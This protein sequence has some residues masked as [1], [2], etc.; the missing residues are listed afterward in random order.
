[1][2]IE[3]KM[4]EIS[5]EKLYEESIVWDAHSGIEPEIPPLMGPLERMRKAGL[6]YTQINVGYDVVPWEKTFQVIG[7]YRSWLRDHADEYLLVGGISD[8]TR[9]KS[10]NKMAVAFDIEGMNALCGSVDLVEVYYR[11]GVRQM[12]IAYNANNLAGGGCHGPDIDLQ[13]FGHDVIA[14]MNEV[15][16][17]VDCS[18]CGYRTTLQAAE[19]SKKPISFSH[20]NSRNLH[21]HERNI[22]DEQIQACASTGGVIG[23]TGVR[24]YLG[25]GAEDA[26]L[27]LR[28]I[29]YMC[30]LV[31]AEHVG[32][33]SDFAD[34]TDGLASL[35]NNEKYYWP[36]EQYPN[37]GEIGFVDIEVFPDIANAL[38]QRGYSEKHIR[39]IMGENF[40]RLAA[41]NWS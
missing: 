25:S 14:A 21:D 17:I 33:G 10:E 30:E 1:M 7:A 27:M 11:L 22:F 24:L 37:G 15:G 9:A 39:G 34:V 8:V 38:V 4:P 41:A 26:E 31:G 20:A 36:P 6:T 2:R 18:H 19:V 23:I 16:M 32:L 5:S 13:P 29:D 28:H 3:T 12:G 35:W 40:I